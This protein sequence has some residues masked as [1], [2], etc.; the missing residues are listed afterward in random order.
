L[1]SIESAKLVDESLGTI[2]HVEASFNHDKLRG[3]AGDN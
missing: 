1:P 2:M 3:I